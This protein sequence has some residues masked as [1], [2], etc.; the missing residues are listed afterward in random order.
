[1]SRL[2]D[3]NHLHHTTGALED[4]VSAS[5]GSIIPCPATGV[6]VSLAFNTAVAAA[7]VDN[8]LGSVV[9]DSDRMAVAFEV[10]DLEDNSAGFAATLDH[11]GMADGAEII[12]SA[13]Y[14][15]TEG[16]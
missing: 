10:L 12:A 15:D 8:T 9:I 6:K 11:C 1:H 4:I 5:T 16:N 7:S 13:S 14:S 3:H 2:P